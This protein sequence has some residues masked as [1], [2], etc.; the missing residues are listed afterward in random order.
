[1]I[2]IQNTEDNECFKWYLARYLHPADHNPRRITQ[3]DK[4]FAKK[5]D[6]KDIKFPVKVRDIR[7]IEKKNSV[8][9]SEFGYENKDKYQTYVLKK[10]CEEKRIDLLLIGVTDKKHYVLIKDFN[11][12]MHGKKHFCR[13]CL[14]AFNTEEILKYHMKD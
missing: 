12:S 10:C 3:A 7:K 8:R 11:T 9:I 2:N 4:D 1:M 5:F 14:Q 13:Y 6:F